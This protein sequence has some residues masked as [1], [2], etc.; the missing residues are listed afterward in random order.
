MVRKGERGQVLI[1]TLLLLLVGGLILTPL[2][3][4][5]STGLLAGQVYERKTLELYS[6]DSGVEYAI[7]GIE[8]GNLTF[9]E[10][11]YSYPS[12]IIVNDREV[13]VDIYREDI[14]STCNEHFIYQILSTAD[15][16][17]IE[18]YLDSIPGGELDIF[19][20]ILSSKSNIEFKG[21]CSTVNG[22]IYVVG[23][24]PGCYNQVQG[25]VTPVTLAAF[26]TL[27]QDLAFAQALKAM[28]TAGQT[29]IGDMDVSSN[30]TLTSTYITGDLNIDSSFTL[31][32]VV[33]VGGGVHV[34][35]DITINGSGPSIGLIAEGN[36]YFQKVSTSGNA[37]DFIL[38]S[39]SSA[40][41]E[42][43]KE[44]TISALVYAPNGPIWFNKTSDIDGGIVGASIRVENEASLNYVQKASGFDLPGGYSGYFVLRS[45]SING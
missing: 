3:G 42:F 45:Y 34:T 4:F 40:G 30:I 17:S 1:L 5:M 12:T 24:I 28:A 39:L 11:N 15:S 29:Y 22:P 43:R 20:G 7:W 35:K 16:T 6:A 31:A 37:D 38:M 10:Y 14:D 41:I 8:R 27:V 33:Y 21:P 36:I 2:L 18:A 25:N 9:D 44:A 23:T 32:G 19:S 13:N 26:P